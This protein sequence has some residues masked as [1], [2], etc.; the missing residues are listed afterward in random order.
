M[1]KKKVLKIILILSVIP[2]IV[3]LIIGVKN[4]FCGYTLFFNTSYG[5]QALIDTCVIYGFVFSCCFPVLPIC[6]VY[7]IISFIF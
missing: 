7:Q 3:I 5:V 2:F 4:A 1:N 6:L